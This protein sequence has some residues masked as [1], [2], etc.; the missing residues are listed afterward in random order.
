MDLSS[1]NSLTSA[2]FIRSSAKRWVLTFSPCSG[3]SDKIQKK[4]KN[5]HYPP[6]SF[7]A[8]CFHHWKYRFCL[9][10][11]VGD[12]CS[13]NTI[14]ALYMSPSSTYHTTSLL[15]VYF[16]VT[17]SGLKALQDVEILILFL[18]L[19]PPYERGTW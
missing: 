15:P 2:D 11:H 4:R 14:K 19:T 10:S 5:F 7:G 3:F 16:S 1:L 18:V 12:E 9:I 6:E 8:G 17:I 13:L